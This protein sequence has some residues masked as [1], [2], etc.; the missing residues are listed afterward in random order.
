MKTVRKIY[1]FDPETQERHIEEVE[2]DMIDAT[3]TLLEE[4]QKVW[5]ARASKSA[6]AQLFQARITKLTPSSVTLEYSDDCRWWNKGCPESSSAR[7]TSGFHYDLR[8]EKNRTYQF[9]QIAVIQ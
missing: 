1:N 9:R 2:L 3:G 8:N 4:G 5:Y 7:L 6:P